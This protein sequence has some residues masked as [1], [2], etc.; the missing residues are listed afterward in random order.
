MKELLLQSTIISLFCV[1]LRIVSSKGMILFFLR[2]PYEWLQNKPIN[3]VGKYD[4]TY[5]KRIRKKN[6]FYRTLI[7]L[8]KPVIGC[9]TCMASFWTLVISHFYFSINQWTLLIIFVVACLN[10]IIM[11]IFENLNK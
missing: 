3:L 2:M 1:G 5:E 6:L 8:L 7:Y 4:T 10:S 9:T 11:A